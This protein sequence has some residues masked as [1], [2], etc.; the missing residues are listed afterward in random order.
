MVDDWNIV[1]GDLNVYLG[2]VIL[3]ATT[4]NQGDLTTLDK[5]SSEIHGGLEG[6]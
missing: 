4:Q 1:L 2:L 3:Q 5:I 6:L